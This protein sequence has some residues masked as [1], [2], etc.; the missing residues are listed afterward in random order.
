MKIR[1]FPKQRLFLLIIV[2]MTLAPLVSI[3]ETNLSD[4]DA[5]LS[6]TVILGDLI[7]YAYQSNPSIREAREAWRATIEQYRLETAFPDPEIMMTYFPDPLETRLGPQDWN[8]NLT[9]KIPFPGKLS[10]AGEV[11]EA[12]AR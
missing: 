4:L 7:E 3:T 9:Q 1:K 6:G 2:G 8:A 12:E 10:K 5:R 11:V